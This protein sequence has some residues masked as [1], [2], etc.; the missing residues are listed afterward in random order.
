MNLAQIRK[1]AD[2]AFKRTQYVLIVLLLMTVGFGEMAHAPGLC[3]SEWQVLSRNLV[4]FT[5]RRVA[6]GQFVAA[7]ESFKQL[8]SVRVAKLRNELLRC[9]GTCGPV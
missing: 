1:F 2:D 3:L 5:V 9:T 8:G 4:E 6:H 7:N